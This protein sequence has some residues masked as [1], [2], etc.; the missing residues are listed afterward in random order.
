MP[1]RDERI[2]LRRGATRGRPHLWSAT[3]TPGPEEGHALVRVEWGRGGD[4]MSTSE[5][6]VGPGDVRPPCTTVL[7]QA[8][9]VAQRL[10]RAKIAKG[11]SVVGCRGGA[12]CD[13][14]KPASLPS[15]AKRFQDAPHRWTRAG[16]V[17]AQ[18]IP[19]GLRASLRLGP[20]ESPQL[21]VVGHGPVPLTLVKGLVEA[22]TPLSRHVGDDAT[23]HGFLA[24]ERVAGASPF[25]GPGRAAEA[26]RTGAGGS[27]KFLVADAFVPAR[28][29]EAFEDRE[30]KL[31]EAVQ[32]ATAESPA[33]VGVVF[34]SHIRGASIS[35]FYVDC[36]LDGHEGAVYR[37]A[38]ALALPDPGV[39]GSHVAEHIEGRHGRFRVRGLVAQPSRPD[40]LSAVMLETPDRE[41]FR[42]RVRL[43]TDVQAALLRDRA[44]LPGR[45]A[46]VW[47]DEWDSSRS[48]PPSGAVVAGV[49]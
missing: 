21:T 10:S 19:H 25:V 4:A 3:V 20:A 18:P 49:L 5:T 8:R 31:P 42:A 24:A 39:H 40:R 27:L 32:R 22:A 12:R 41:P 2:A 29:E 45:L 30:A 28:R 46:I 17:F 7:G 36:I 1:A 43:P 16:S 13:E 33:S 34:T 6:R 38:E 26:V 37:M 47:F 14:A 9:E 48:E 11:Y 35:T 15:S 23:L 44:D